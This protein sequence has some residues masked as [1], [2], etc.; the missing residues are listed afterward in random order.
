MKTT[1]QKLIEDIKAID[2]RGIKLT[3]SGFLTILESSLDSERTQITTAFDEG[4]L[5]EKSILGKVDY[6]NA[7]YFNSTFEVK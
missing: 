6:P 3:N 2:G 1:V 7:R 4:R 5:Y